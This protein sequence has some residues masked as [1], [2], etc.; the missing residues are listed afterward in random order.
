MA[1]ASQGSA[2]GYA[3]SIKAKPFQQATINVAMRTL[4]RKKKGAHR[5]LV[6]DEVGLGKTIVASGI[7]ERLADRK[8]A[9]GSSPLSVLYVCSNQ[10]I[11][12]QNT[13]RLLSFLPE[14]ERKSAVAHVDR[15]SLLPTREPPTHERIH[16]YMLTP[17][18]AI[19]TRKGQRRDGRMEERA[20]GLVFLCRCGA[21]PSK[22]LYRAFQRNAGGESFRSWVHY[23]RRLDEFGELGSGEFRNR[24][25]DALRDVLGL[26]QGQH[27]P[28]RLTQM[29]DNQQEQDLVGAC[30][31]ALTVAALIGIDAGLVIFDEFQ[32]FRDLMEDE[33][34]AEKEDSSEEE[35][36]RRRAA[37]RVLE[38][39]RGLPDGGGPALLLSATPYTPYRRRT[40]QS[41]PGGETSDQSSDFF[42]LV[43]FLAGSP[44]AAE[45]ARNLFLDLS[46]EL[47]KGVLDSVR[48]QTIRNSLMSVLLPLMSRTERPN[49]P[50]I[51]GTAS[52]SASVIDAELLPSDIG[53]FCDMQE[54][55]SPG[56]YDWIVPLWQSVPLPMQ[57]L[58]SRYLAWRS[59]LK[60][61]DRVALTKGGRDTHRMPM[62]WPH[63]RLRALM[64]K[65]ADKRLAM[66]WAAPSLPWWPLRGG[67]KAVDHH[68]SI[69]GKLLVFS[70]FKAVPT[71]LAGL[72]SYTTESR[73][74]SKTG[75]RSRVNYEAASKR[76]WLQ[77]SPDRPNLLELF[78]PCRLLAELDPLAAPFG[79]LAGMRQV[80]E[81][82]LKQRLKELG[83]GIVPGG[84][85]ARRKP[86]ELLVALEKKAG[87]WK[88][89][90]AA[91]L[92]VAPSMEDED[93]VGRLGVMM[94]KW[95]EVANEESPISEI[96]REIDLPAL[97]ALA[98]ESPAVVLLR[99]LSRH[100]PAAGNPENLQTV[101]SA[102]WRGLRTYL[103]KAWFVS[104][105]VE[106]DGGSY[107]DA[108][109]K[110]I[111]E[112]NLESVL[113]EHFWFLS[114]D[115][116]GDWLVRLREFESSL[117]LRDSNVTFHESSAA[118]GSDRSDPAAFTVRC[119][120]AVPLAEG[121]K[122]GSG[123]EVPTTD[124][125]VATNEAD[126]PLRPDEVRK[127]FNSPFWPN[128]LVT[129]S[130]GQEGLD[131]HPWCS[132]LAHW[133]L[134]TSP[135][136]LEQ[137]EG[138]ITRFASLSVRRAIARKLSTDLDRCNG[139][140]P[141][142]RLASLAETKLNDESGLS[143]W[144]LVEGSECKRFVLTVLG[145]E[146][147]ERYETLVRERALY[148]LV[149][150]MPDQSDLIRLLDAQG[151]D[152]AS[153]RSACIDLSAYNNR[154][155]TSA[156]SG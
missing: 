92:G 120:V 47:R 64:A 114:T 44:R 30:R 149:L 76:R 39:I 9:L 139:S 26:Q 127:A 150:G 41:V 71:S 103:D 131:L 100:W 73:L 1:G 4:T 128:V 18:T 116:I 35:E 87:M 105:L 60:M 109:R 67:W 13:L 48:A 22:R 140:S 14:A 45:R 21:K 82:Q 95:D 28:P 91:W 77:P 12:R 106:R 130:I 59:K 148:R 55:F 20:L 122:S 69:E 133:D 108:I 17:D 83:V 113:D 38:A 37:S 10:A 143:P 124:K 61:P 52:D 125:N 34:P 151:K 112:G 72:I 142:E 93:S 156:A 24:F 135:V 86:W 7:I 129:T 101:L 111:I 107:P 153:L 89:S 31:T 138:R 85:M 65:M 56:S 42:D 63:P 145:G 104:V 115:G 36:M 27:L 15:P 57:T 94:E 155:H 46:E 53:Q 2:P 74:L 102:I 84:K 40:K 126:M 68:A 121:R 75:G 33:D 117:R 110:A 90:R 137:R 66:P 118:E 81:Q 119:H 49:L 123:G 43:S 152:P 5:F 99:A 8:M 62:P 11:A 16:I 6:A 25:R 70:R 51:Q 141:W 154:K 29:L 3:M 146:Q 134:A 50:R 98:L 97:V 147:Q 79:N 32:R 54:C 136:A 144:W 19:P 78:H 80:I 58:G 88:A 96:S 23:Y 132:A